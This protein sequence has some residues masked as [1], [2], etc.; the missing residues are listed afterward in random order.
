MWDTGL[1]SDVDIMVQLVI[2]GL[3][4]Y[5]YHRFK[6]RHKLRDHGLIFTVATVLNTA[7]ILFLMIPDFL[8][9]HLQ[10]ATIDVTFL[11]ILVH[12]AFGGIAEILAVWIVI[13]WYWNG[14]SF[15]KCEGK[16]VMR[17]TY[18]AW[19]TAL[20]IGFGLFLFG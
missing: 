10:E 16:R 18:S 13:R 9:N 8:L 15:K 3:L 17:L 4:L 11:V 14:K 12:V 7:T 6:F 19:L 2:L 20:A 5:G 1:A